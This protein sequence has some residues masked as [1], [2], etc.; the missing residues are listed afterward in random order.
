MQGTRVAGVDGCPAGWLRVERLTNGTLHA[1]ILSTPALFAEAEQ[2]HTIAIDIPIGLSGAGDRLVDRRAREILG[3]PRSSSVFSA[4]P[5]DVLEANSYSDACERSFNACGKRMSRQAFGI[6]AKIRDVDQQLRSAMHL[7][8]RVHEAHPEVSFSFMAGGQPMRHSKRTREGLTE[9][10]ALLDAHFGDVFANLRTR[11]RVSKVHSDDI[12]DAMVL[13]WSAE[14]IQSATHVTLCKEV[15]RDD[16]G[17][18]MQM[19]A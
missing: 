12:A 5:R 3:A 8:G 7:I 13:L 14:R 16:C 1:D 19:L 9:R 10:V 11:F 2:F 18:P 15:A 4:P 6:L 17:I